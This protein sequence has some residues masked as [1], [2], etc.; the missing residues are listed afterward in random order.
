MA[1]HESSRTPGLYDRRD[2]EVSLD[3]VERIGI[4]QNCNADPDA[5]IQ[6]ILVVGKSNIAATR[7]KVANYCCKRVR[8]GNEARAQFVL[9]SIS[10]GMAHNHRPKPLSSTDTPLRTHRPRQ[11]RKAFGAECVM[12]P[13]CSNTDIAV[14]VITTHPKAKRRKNRRPAAGG[15]KPYGPHGC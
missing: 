5:W 14:I 1:A 15:L 4:L 6:E 2:D 10:V 9:S 8:V 11:E 13:P 7:R 3:E 12:E